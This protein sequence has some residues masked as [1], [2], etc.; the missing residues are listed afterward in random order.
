MY[1]GCDVTDLTVAGEGGG[2]R[3]TVRRASR[4]AS[5]GDGAAEAARGDLGA[6]SALQSSA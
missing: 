5:L 3:A 6:A 2:F 1:R 4:R